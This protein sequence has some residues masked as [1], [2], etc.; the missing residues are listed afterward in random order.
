MAAKIT[1]TRHTNAL[2]QTEYHH[3]TDR[4]RFVV[5]PNADRYSKWE[6]MVWTLRTVGTMEPI[7][8]IR[9]RHVTS[10]FAETL[11]EARED[12]A[13]WIERQKVWVNA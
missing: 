13:A 1:F 5:R 9:D 11:A 7:L 10:I 8:K 2:G 3:E 6:M 12:I 4:F